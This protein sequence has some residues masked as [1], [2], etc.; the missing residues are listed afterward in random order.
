MPARQVTDAE[1]TVQDPLPGFDPPRHKRCSVCRELKPL[2]EFHRKVGAKD[3]LQARCKPCNIESAKR[4]HAANGEECRARISKRARRLH[5]RNQEL[6][7]EYLMA[8][9]CV[10]CGMTDIVTLDF[11]H[12]RDKVANVSALTHKSWPVILAEI[13]KCEVVCANCH[14][15]RTAARSR[16]IR[17]R[18]WS[19]RDGGN[20]PP[21]V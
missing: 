17:H 10:D 15:R 5:Q 8:H 3:G 12:L 1:V 20:V 11:D 21:G 14:R 4:F 7:A 9:P 18:I 13:E 2:T 6:I 16:T 19:E